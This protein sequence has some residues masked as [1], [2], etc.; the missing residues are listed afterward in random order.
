MRVMGRPRAPRAR[1]VGLG[2]ERNS[3]ERS[4]DRE[5]AATAICR[6]TALRAGAP[7]ARGRTPPPGISTLFVAAAQPPS[8]A[9]IAPQSVIADSISSCLMPGGI[10]NDGFAFEWHAA[11]LGAAAHTGGRRT[12]AAPRLRHPARTALSHLRPSPERRLTAP[13]QRTNTCNFE[14]LSRKGRR[15]HA[16]HRRGPAPGASPP[17]S[18]GAR[19]FASSGISDSIGR[20]HVQDIDAEWDDSTHS[21]RPRVAYDFR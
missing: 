20:A 9:A 12:D 16:C 18:C 3:R 14:W 4:S 13:A 1:P 19:R 6:T 21:A 8:L 17:R 11:V 7:S 2:R 5:P 10:Y 15:P